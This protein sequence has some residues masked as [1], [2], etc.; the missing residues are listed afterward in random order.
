MSTQFW[1][2]HSFFKQ[3][4]SFLWQ[5]RRPDFFFSDWL[6]TTYRSPLC[7]QLVHWQW[8]RSSILM[9]SLSVTLFS[10][11]IGLLHVSTLT[12]GLFQLLPVWALVYGGLQEDDTKSIS[13]TYTV[14]FL[15]IYFRIYYWMNDWI[16]LCFISSWSLA[17]RT[18]IYNNISDRKWQGPWPS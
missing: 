6:S 18:Y 15:K 1:N 14:A 5:G 2:L 10:P 9:S 17:I 4:S 3:L 8:R 12:D 11:S 16:R 7:P 13:S